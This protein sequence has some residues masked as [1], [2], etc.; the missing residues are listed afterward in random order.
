[1]DVDV[2]E[3]LGLLLLLLFLA[4]LLPCFPFLRCFLVV[5]LTN[6]GAGGGKAEG[7]VG[8]GRAMYMYIHM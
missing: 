2:I 3:E 1:M 5:L 7:E 4:S 8:K 6:S